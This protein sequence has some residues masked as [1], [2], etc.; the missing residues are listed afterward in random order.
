MLNGGVFFS[1]RSGSGCRDAADGQDRAL[2]RA[3]DGFVS[4]LNAAA[5]CS[6]EQRAVGFLFALENFCKATEEQGS[7]HAGVASCAAKQGAG[8][9]FCGF[10]K[11]R[12]RS[13]KQI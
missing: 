9:D 8:S 3:H 4:G 5:E 7:D 2:R 10:G 6:G 13:L 11:S 1:L 12:I